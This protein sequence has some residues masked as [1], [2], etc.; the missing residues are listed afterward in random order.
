MKKTK[1]SLELE[2]EQIREVISNLFSLQTK[3]F[4][5]KLVEILPSLNHKLINSEKEEIQL[6]INKVIEITEKLIS[7]IKSIE[8]HLKH[9]PKI[10]KPEFPR[11]SADGESIELGKLGSKGLAI[12][13]DGTAETLD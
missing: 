7:D 9:L 4:S 12:H 5:D 1:L 3:S 13:P 10:P 2:K 11:Q 6:D 8:K